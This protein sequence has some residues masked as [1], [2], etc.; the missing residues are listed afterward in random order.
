MGSTCKI[1]VITGDFSSLPPSH[2]FWLRWRHTCSD[3]YGLPT[4]VLAHT[5]EWPPGRCSISS[6]P[7][8]APA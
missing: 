2:L 3:W 7:L 4:S 1:A 8:P 5:I 6:P